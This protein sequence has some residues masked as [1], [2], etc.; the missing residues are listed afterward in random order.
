MIYSVRRWSCVVSSLICI[1][2]FSSNAES[3]KNVLLFLSPPDVNDSMDKSSVRG[4][5]AQT[6]TLCFVEI[7]EVLNVGSEFSY[8][9]MLIHASAL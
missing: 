3:E 6:S 7:A 2:T 4:D 1:G 9:F 8:Y 5:V